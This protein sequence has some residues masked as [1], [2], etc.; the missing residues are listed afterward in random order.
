MS[1]PLRSS[2]LA[3]ISAIG[4]ADPNALKS[5]A[6]PNKPPQENA[7]V[8][9]SALGRVRAELRMV[10]MQ[11]DDL[12]AALSS[13]ADLTRKMTDAAREKEEAVCESFRVKEKPQEWLSQGL[14]IVRSSTT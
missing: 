6:D 1:A 13:W 7:A 14:T 8:L 12:R 11:I 10:E 9:A 4:Q 5:A 3:T 2:I